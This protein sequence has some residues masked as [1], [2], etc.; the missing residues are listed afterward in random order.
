MALTIAQKNV[1]SEFQQESTE[2]IKIKY[3]MI[4]LVQMYTNEN[5]GA[6]TDSDLLTLPETAHVTAA[7]LQAAGTA[8][9]AINT[10]LGDFS[11]ASNVAK[12]LKIVTAVPR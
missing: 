5:I 4:A 3:R 10:T 6:V 1:L 8:L 9:A 7:E 12:L 11:A 2:L